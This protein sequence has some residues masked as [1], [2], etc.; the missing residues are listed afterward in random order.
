MAA[1]APRS[2][3]PRRLFSVDRATGGRVLRP[4]DPDQSDE[5]HLGRGLFAFSSS[6]CRPHRLNV[7]HPRSLSE[8]SSTSAAAGV[9]KETALARLRLLQSRRASSS[10]WRQ[11]TATLW[12]NASSS[13]CRCSMSDR[14][15]RRPGCD[16][17][18]VQIANEA[19][20][21][22]PHQ[23]WAAAGWTVRSRS[24]G[25][26]QRMGAAKAA[27]PR[28]YQQLRLPAASPAASYAA[29]AEDHRHQDQGWRAGK[30]PRSRAPAGSCTP[31]S[32]RP[33]DIGIAEHPGD[34]RRIAGAAAP[35][36][37]SA[38]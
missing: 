25:L 13:W 30:Q 29:S 2:A 32:P 17:R 5:Q 35:P 38:S 37:L 26:A 21:T 6:Y 19:M 36:A 28:S 8:V 18:A 7:D 9:Q 24:R 20:T 22:S 27:R 33:S 4:G 34:D 3:W 10:P 31:P 11:P 16:Q 1:A 15:A 12:R 23:R 14:P